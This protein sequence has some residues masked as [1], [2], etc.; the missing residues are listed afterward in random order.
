MG[1][2]V[3]LAAADMAFTFAALDRGLEELN[4][5]MAFLLDTGRGVAALV[6]VGITAGLAATGWWF[7]RYRRVIEAGQLVAAIMSLVLV[8][9]LLGLLVA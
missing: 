8:Y 1:S 9:H 6:K 7:R 4:P 3:A 5:V 2:I